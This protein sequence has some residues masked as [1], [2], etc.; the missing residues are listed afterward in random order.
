MQLSG[1]YH[2]PFKASELASGI[3]F[4]ELQTNDRF[5]RHRMMLLNKVSKLV[6]TK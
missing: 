6:L 4:L 3:Y 5:L 1:S 2:I